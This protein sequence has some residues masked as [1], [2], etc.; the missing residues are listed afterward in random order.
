MMIAITSTGDHIKTVS[1]RR[2][3]DTRIMFSWLSIT[4]PLSLVLAKE[5]ILE[6]NVENC[7][8]R[9]ELLLPT[10]LSRPDESQF[11]IGNQSSYKEIRQCAFTRRFLSRF[12]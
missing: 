8:I 11:P 12:G 4:L 3:L 10:R 2:I 5:Y 1:T 9:I 6:P 7:R